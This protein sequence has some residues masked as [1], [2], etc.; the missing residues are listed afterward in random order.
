M[1][2]NPIWPVEKRRP[3]LERDLK[4]DVLVIGGGMAGV[5]CARS[6]M[7]AGREVALIERDELGGPA[8]GA[9]SGVLYYGSGTNYLEAVK[10]FG[11][12][13]ADSLWLETARVI[14]EIKDTARDCKIDCGIRSCG[15]IMVAQNDGQLADVEE[16]HAGLQKLGLPTRLLSPDALKTSYPLVEFAGGIAFDA[17]GQVHPARLAS[18]MAEHE[19]IPVYEKTP[20]EGWEESADKVM[21]KTPKARIECTNLVVATNLEPFLGLETHFDTEGSVI[22]ASAP[23]PRVKEAFPEEKILWTMEEKYDIVYPRGDRLILELYQL[24]DEDEKL[25]RYFPGIEFVTDQIWGEN[26]SKPRD[27]IPIA[28]MVSKR[29]AVAKGMGDQGIIMSWLSGKKMPGILE[30]KSDWFTRLTSP[31]RFFPGG[32]MPQ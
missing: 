30:G 5:S 27:W 19:G 23:T 17:V 11:Q 1:Q 8:T 16:E 3:P 9:S 2:A 15:S 24:G 32:V 25:R 18:A 12:Q 29:T 22:L 13:N 7:R 20:S 6:L 21:V 28:G 4:V 10:L 26:W 31:Q 14:Q